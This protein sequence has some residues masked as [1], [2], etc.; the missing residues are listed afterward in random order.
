MLLSEAEDH[1][2]LRAKGKRAVDLAQSETLSTWRRSLTG[3]WDVSL[4][5]GEVS[6][7][8]LAKA[9]GET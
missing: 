4:T 9:R 8:R 7:G 1:I 3:T 5:P 6:P 2:A